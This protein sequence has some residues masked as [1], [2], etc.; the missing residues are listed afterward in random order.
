[1]KNRREKMARIDCRETGRR[2]RQYMVL[3]GVSVHDVQDY[4]SLECVQS[5]YH[6]L[7]GKCLPTLDNLYC[8]S[9]LLQVPMDSLVAGT[10]TKESQ[11]YGSIY[12]RGHIYENLMENCFAV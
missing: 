10:R 1:M 8:L 6:W 12:L 11:W 5:V 2:I 4:L 3:R 9:E 7:A